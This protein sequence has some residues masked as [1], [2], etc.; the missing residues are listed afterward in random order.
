MVSV[1]YYQDDDTALAG[2]DYVY[3]TGVLEFAPGETSKTFSVSVL[4]DTIDE[5]D[6][7]FF[8]RLKVPTNATIA[9][10]LAVATIVDDDT[11][12]LSVS[13]SVVTEGNSG[14]VTAV[15][16]VTLSTASS[17]TAIVF[18]MSFPR[19]GCRTWRNLI[20]GWSSADGTES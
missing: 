14:T 17:Q 11:A 12:L 8:G 9:D 1:A 16:S 6:E 5:T 20:A 18:L 3:T 15:F 10:D 4:G 7:T 13:D 19:V 2:D